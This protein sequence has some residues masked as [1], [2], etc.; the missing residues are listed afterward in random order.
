M[1]CSFVGVMY[2]N[3]ESWKLKS[4]IWLTVYYL[5]FGYA[6]IE[7]IKCFNDKSYI[8]AEKNLDLRLIPHKS[9]QG[10]FIWATSIIIGN[11]ILLL[12]L[13]IVFKSDIK[14]YYARVMFKDDLRR[15][16]SL[17]KVRSDYPLRFIQLSSSFFKRESDLTEDEKKQELDMTKDNI[18]QDEIEGKE[19]ELAKSPKKDDKKV[20]VADNVSSMSEGNTLCIICYTNP[21]NTLVEPCGHGGVCEECIFQLI[22]KERIC[23]F[24]RKEMDTIYLVKKTPGSNVV[25]LDKEIALSVDRY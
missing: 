22:K 9:E 15:E 10:T 5:G 6:F 3:L 13:H 8:D 2:Q 25:K 24:C 20:D 19:K 23:P 7:I 4:L 14:K 17:K 16:I 11:S 1:V 21:P 12:I 18:Q